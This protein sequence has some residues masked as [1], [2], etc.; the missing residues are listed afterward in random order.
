MSASELPYADLVVESTADSSSLPSLSALYLNRFIL[1]VSEMD[2]VRRVIVIGVSS[3]ED[4][5]FSHFCHLAALLQL[6]PVAKE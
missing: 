3:L 2:Y 6:F 4:G 1:S 5:A